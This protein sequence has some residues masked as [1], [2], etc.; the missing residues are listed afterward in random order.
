VV[1]TE[2]RIG[3]G[4]LPLR[5]LPGAGVGLSGDAG[6]LLAELRAGSP[7]VVALL[8]QDRVVLDVRCVW[9]VGE[10][11]EAVASAAGRAKVRAARLEGARLEE[12]ETEG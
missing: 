5:K 3:G 6:A 10:L 1:E 8:R 4:S 12:E 11:A 2:G 7:A 9:D